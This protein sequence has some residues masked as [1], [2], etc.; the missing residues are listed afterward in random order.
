MTRRIITLSPALDSNFDPDGEGLAL[1]LLKWVSSISILG[2][3]KASGD[4]FQRSLPI[5]LCLGMSVAFI[6]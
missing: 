4:H 3:A 6:E 1:G 5:A 2:G